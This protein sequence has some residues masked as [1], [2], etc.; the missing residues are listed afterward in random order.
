MF[1]SFRLRA[2]HWM[3]AILA[4]LSLGKPAH[5]SIVQISPGYFQCSTKPGMMAREDIGTYSAHREIHGRIHLVADRTDPDWSPT[6]AFLFELNGKRAV[7]VAVRK[8]RGDPDHIY[9]GVWKHETPIILLARWDIAAWMP[10]SV[11]LSE[12]GQLTATAG[13][14]SKSVN[15]GRGTVLRRVIHCNS[16]AFDFA[17]RPDTPSRSN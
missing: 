8:V 9:A 12:N 6:A 17:L 10:L 7:G 14:F 3:A 2:S 1:G 15:V 4:S 11:K 16:G 5:A 13:Q